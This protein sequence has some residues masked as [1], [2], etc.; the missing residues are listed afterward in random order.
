MK[1]LL[2]AAIAAIAFATIPMA[3]Q[4][5]G[6]LA[7]PPAE[8]LTINITGTDVDTTEL[9]IETGKYYRIVLVSDGMNEVG[10]SAPE[11][12]ADI[13]IRLIVI[14]GIEVHLQG[15][16]FRSIEFDAGGTAAFSFVAIRPGTYTFMIGEVQGT[17][18]VI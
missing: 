8:V 5:E 7:A 1:K 11:F 10:F 13:H 6:N 16:S 3:A 14:E 9:N 2:A 18:N 4:A 17:I 15:L 12:I